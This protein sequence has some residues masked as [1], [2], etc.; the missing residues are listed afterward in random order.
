V[1]QA[2][3]NQ[4]QQRARKIAGAFRSLSGPFS[5][6]V[7]FSF[8]IN[9]LMLVAPLYMLQ[10]YDRVLSS[11]NETTLIMLTII[12]AGLL[13][14]FGLLE[15]IRS[16]VLVRIGWKL[17]EKLNA[18]VFKAVFARSV[19]KGGGGNSQSLRDLDSVREFLTGQGLIAFCDAPWVPVFLAVVFMFHP[20]LGFVALAGAIII[21]TLALSNEFATRKPLAEAS[22]ESVSADS[23]VTTSLRNAEAVQAMG[24]MPGILERW[25][26]KHADVLSRQSLASDR[27]GAILA[28]SKSIRMMLQVGILGTGAYLAIQR[29][30]TPG[31]MIAASILMGRA[32]APVESA[33][34]QWRGFIK[35]RSAFSRLNELM[36]A[37]EDDRDPMPLPAPT[38]EISAE[39][40]VVVPPGTRTPVLRGV[41]FKIEPGETLGVI[42]PSGAGKSSL[43][44]ALMGIWPVASGGIRLDGADIHDWDKTQLGPYLGYLPQ[45]VELFEG[46]VAENIARFREV[47]PDEVVRAAKRAGVHEMI[48]RLPNGYDTEIGASGQSLSGG[49]R[50]RVGLARAL[51]NDVRVVLLDEPN[52]NLDTAGEKALLNA[53]AEMKKAG[54]TV[55]MI[56]HRP[57]LL[58]TADKVLALDNGQVQAFGPRQ[59]VLQKY[60][61]PAAVSGGKDQQQVAGPQGGGPQV[62][63]SQSGGQGQ[64]GEQ[65][66]ESGPDESEAGGTDA[67][68]GGEEPRTGKATTV[69]PFS[70]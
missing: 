46:T 5:A 38:G 39:N 26:K 3:A 66:G 19:M 31:T 69:T 25:R 17:D 49:Q 15:L 10:V 61:R 41:R 27:A 62:A 12:A 65:A 13:V 18:D 8:F 48:L 50:Q 51:Y 35:A 16:R 67:G 53:L 40:A 37:Q 55:I 28:S 36:L 44:R 7:V 33:V 14:V 60:T 22:K 47:D 45:D 6:T 9:L 59:E 2:K 70:R 42:G 32:L 56:T 29:E 23:F 52:A 68:D 43:A 54:V 1:K 21:F 58:G 64:A 24:M 63:G 20:L 11:R 57:P 34:G 4:K 30:I